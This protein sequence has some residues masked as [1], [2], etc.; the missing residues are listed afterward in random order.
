MYVKFRNVLLSFLLVTACTALM[1]MM[2]LTSADVAMRYL[3]NNPLVWSHELTEICM[4]I[5]VPASVTYCSYK[6]AH[7]SVDLLYIHLPKKL[8]AVVFVFAEG[9]AAL[10]MGLLTWKSV[11]LIEEL[12][13]MNTITPDLGIPMW[14]IGVFFLFT[15]GLTTVLTLDNARKGDSNE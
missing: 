4:G 9:V 12:V 13:S 3:F 7:V 14:P 1:A 2:L 10:C 11:D 15:F 5:M 6:G 8:R